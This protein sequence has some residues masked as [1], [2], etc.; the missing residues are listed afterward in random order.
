MGVCGPKNI[1]FGK[2]PTAERGWMQIMKARGWMQIMKA[3]EQV[4]E[5]AAVTGDY[6]KA[7][8]AFILNPQVPGGATA[9]RVLD[10]LL[11]AHEKYLPQFKD[12]IESLKAQ[13][14]TIKDERVRKL[15][16]EGK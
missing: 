3:M 6:N 9:K 14:V 4:T 12:A 15:M 7:L 10:E 8:T 13:G 1:A 5:E 16:A 11:I 2:L